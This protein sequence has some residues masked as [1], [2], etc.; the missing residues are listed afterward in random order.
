MDVVKDSLNQGYDATKR[1]LSTAPPTDAYLQW[2]APGVEEVQ[3]DEEAKAQQIADTMNKMQ[4]H[5]FD[6]VSPLSYPT[7]TFDI[8]VNSH[9]H[10]HAFRATHVKTQGLVKGTLTVLTGLPPHLSQGLFAH[11]GTYAVAA[12]Y[13]NEPV[14]L[15]P[16][17]EPGP[18]G[19]AIKIFHVHGERLETPGNENLSTQDF[20]FNNAP[21][22]ELTDIDTCLE[23]MQLREKY[24]DSP[25][26]LAMALKLRTD[27][28][29]QHAPGMLPNTNMISHS[30]YTQSAFRFGEYYG[31]MAMFP[32]LSE[33]KQKSSDA[34][35]SSGSYTQISDRL[36]DY[37]KGASAKYELKIQ[38]GTSPAHHPTEDASIVWD[39]T[40]APYQTI[41]TV[42]FPV[43]TSFNQERRVFWEDHM[44]LDPWKGLAAHRPLGSINR[45]RKVV[46]GRSRKKRD[47]LNVKTSLDIQNMNQ[48]P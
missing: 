26:K 41:G 37:F 4:T 48:V 30:M 2:D 14:F 46:Y 15:Q 11:P 9:Q 12:R 31:H 27:A 25:N 10:R 19:M 16:D 6:K 39:E 23:I 5:N 1:A 36:F 47:E 35:S 18:R 32:T 22:I 24:F 45:L 13:A 33:M 7:S 40:T 44:V 21:M 42:E 17:T 20:F 34:V 38:L 43:Q 28:I 3:P 29:K 8:S